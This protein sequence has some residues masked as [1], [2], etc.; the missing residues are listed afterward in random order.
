MRCQNVAVKVRFHEMYSIC[1]WI[2][3]LR[4]VCSAYDRLGELQNTTRIRKHSNYQEIR[5]RGVQLLQFS[6]VH[7][8]LQR[9]VSCSKGRSF[10]PSWEGIT[11]I[12][13]VSFLTR[14]NDWLLT[15][16]P[17]ATSTISGSMATR[18]TIRWYSEWK[19]R[20]VHREGVF[21]SWLL[22]WQSS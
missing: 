14:S 10:W 5:V 4:E 8:L 15:D 21:L 12:I 17:I 11:W 22:R 2:S 16:K 20:T 6:S 19:W 3:V 13:L 7:R 1:H 18:V 9:K